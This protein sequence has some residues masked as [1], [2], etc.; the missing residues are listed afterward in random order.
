MKLY[1]SEAILRILIFA[2]TRPEAIKVAPI[3]ISL[4]EHPDFDVSLVSSGQHHEMLYQAFADFGLTPDID[5]K[6]MRPGQT[7][8]SLSSRLFNSVDALLER[9]RPE[10]ILVQGDTTTVMVVALCAFYRGIQVGHVEAGLR[11]FKLDAPFPEELNR[12]IASVVAGLHFAPTEAAKANL[13]REHVD[14]GQIVVTGN[15][16]IDALF[17][18]LQHGGASNELLPKDILRNLSKGKRLILVTGHR[19]ENFGKGFESICRVLSKIVELHEDAFVVYPVHLNPRVKVPVTQILGEKNRI[20][21][22]QP[23]QYKAFIALMNAASIILTDSGGIQE[24]AP[25]LG[26]PVLVM[27]DVTERPEGVAAGT[28]K[29]VGTDAEKII[30]KVSELLTDSSAYEK[31]AKAVNP[32]G[33]GLA[34]QR[35]RDALL[36][37]T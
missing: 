31:M 6:V 34:S 29:L 23:L 17:W 11:S 26:K 18:M 16:V 19:R 28:A 3:V 20:H 4:R 5:L 35:I 22:I 12:R 7:L 14:E 8:A 32:Y 13:I 10:Y 2:G 1:E 36:A 27:R 25:A 15:T 30:N 24:E 33:D 21:L 9:E 37:N